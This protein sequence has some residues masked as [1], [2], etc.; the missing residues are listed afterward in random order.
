M[1]IKARSHCIYPRG[2]IP[3]RLTIFQAGGHDA[4][5]TATDP[6]YRE[7]GKNIYEWMLA[8]TRYKLLSLNFTE[9]LLLFAYR[10][11]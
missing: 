7:R 4:W 9:S 1:I 8:S 11:C 3:A 5:T 6:D 2:F 10:N